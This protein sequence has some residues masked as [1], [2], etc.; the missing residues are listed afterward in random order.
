M[1]KTIEKIVSLCK[2]R[3]FVFQSSDIYG[4]FSAIYDYGPLGIELKNQISQ[5]WWKEMTQINE[6]IVGL[7]SGI[8]M[9]PK[10]WEASGHVG[11]FNDPLIDC[12]KCKARFRTDEF[13]DIKKNQ[14]WG[15]IQCLNCGNKGD[16]TNPRQFNLMFK[17]NI[18]PVEDEGTEA[19]LRPE[20]AQGIYVNYLLVQ[21]SMRLKIPFGIAQ[22]GKA[23]RNEIIARNFIFRT[24]EFEQMEMQYFVKPGS[25]DAAFQQWKEKRFNF[26]HEILNINK[27]K[28][29][30]HQHLDN[31]LAHYAKEACDIE[32]KFPFG[33]SEIEGIH[34]RTNFDLLQ[35]EKFSGK[36]LSYFDQPNNER[37]L[38]YIIETSSGLNRMLLTVLADSFWE[39]TDNKRI[40][41]KLNPKIAPIKA[42]ICPLTKKDG[43]PEKARKIMSILKPHFKVIFDQ[44]G[45]IGKRYYR[46]D[47]AG[48][49]YGITID[50]QT[51]EDN[52]VTIRYRD[53][54]KQTRVLSERLLD[55][56][57]ET[58]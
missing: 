42:A 48:T 16:L 47:E 49:P 41:L 50:H 19:Y 26:Y 43:L 13:K 58:V 33:W 24:R 9:H 29:R 56:I 3:G 15:E 51:L 23:F 54:Q 11:A 40:V 7:D 2:R 12:K 14:N 39:D 20:T 32:Y 52:T 53:T 5:L 37:F 21:G 36:K 22:V 45:S 57:N 55:I 10:I 44:Q 1:D 17:T 8:L 25:D 46:Q 30:F 28:L 18:G 27:A 6:N 31:E 34:N 4:G 35:H 38:P